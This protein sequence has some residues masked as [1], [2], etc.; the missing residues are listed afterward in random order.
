MDFCFRESGEEA[1]DESE[2]GKGAARKELGERGA[3]S[4]GQRSS[5]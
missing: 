1:E 4:R 2:T 5:G 3:G